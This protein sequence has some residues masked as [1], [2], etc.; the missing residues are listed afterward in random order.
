MNRE[1]R[2]GLAM[3]HITSQQSG[4]LHVQERPFVWSGRRAAYPDF[5]AGKVRH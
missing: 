4:P 3:P 1:E 5:G 2:G